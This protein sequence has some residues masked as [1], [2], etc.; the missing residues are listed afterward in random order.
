[1]FVN[2]KVSIYIPTKNR[3]E[4]LKKA[5]NSVLEQTYSNFELIIVNDGSTDSTA[6]YLDDLSQKD[7][8]IKIIHHKISKGACSA[9]NDAIFSA[10]G[11]FITGLDDDDLFYKDRLKIFIENWTEE[12]KIVGIASYSDILR[13]NK[14]QKNKKKETIYL[15]QRDLLYGNPIWNPIFTKTDFLKEH[16]GF[17]SNFAMLQDFDCWY[18]LLEKG[19]IIKI[20]PYTTYL[21]DNEDR[22]DRITNKQK[23]IVWDTYKLFVEKHHLRLKEA[24]IFRFIMIYYKVERYSLYF[25]FKML[26][27]TYFDKNTIL[28][29]NSEYLFPLLK[30]VKNKF[31]IK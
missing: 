7:C 24:N 31:S 27:F 5:V 11:D 9:R 25:Y 12:K 3:L 14:I 10:T 22:S 2:P 20:I 23:S 8:R 28:K 1:M 13:N 30:I 6:E 29:M 17:D 16:R 21:I 4:L 26:F 19:N 18:R 15:K